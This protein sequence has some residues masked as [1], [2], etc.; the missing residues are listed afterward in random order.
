MA[1]T[2]S[3]AKIRA[4]AYNSKSI[5]DDTIVENTVF[6][7]TGTFLLLSNRAIPRN[8]KVYIETTITSNPN[9]RDIRHLPLCLGVH[10]EPSFGVLGSDCSLGGV[11][12]TR[13]AYIMGPDTTGY[14]AFTIRDKYAGQLMK[15][16]Y[17]NDTGG[18][19][20]IRGTVIGLGVDMVNNTISIYTD[21]VLFYSWIPSE[22]V[23]NDEPNDFFFAIYCSEHNEPLSGSINFGR[24]R[25]KYLPEGYMDFYQELYDKQ[26]SIGE[27]ECNIKV[28]SPYDYTS[29][30]DILNGSLHSQNDIA[31][32]D[33]I[34]HRRDIPLV[35]N[36]PD[37]MIYY[38]DES[39]GI[40]NEHA[41]T[42]TDTEYLG[43]EDDMAYIKFPIGQNKKIYFEFHSS[44]ATM[45]E[46]QMGIPL[47]IGVTKNV[48]DL[49]KDAFH[50]NLYHLR[51]D[52]YHLYTYKDGIGF[53][54]GNYNIMN[55][56]APV[57]PNEIGVLLDLENNTI[58]L[59]T[60]G[61][62][63]TIVSPY[64]SITSFED[65]TEPVYF[66]FK[67]VPEVFTGSGHVIVNLGTRSPSQMGA[68]TDDPAL[69]GFYDEDFKWKIADNQYVL[70]YW[71]YYNYPLNQ[72]FYKDLY[73]VMKVVSDHISY[74]RYISSTITIPEDT[75]I[76]KG[77][78]PG[79]NRLNSTYNKVTDI[80]ERNNVPTISIYDLKKQI[81]EDD[82][83]R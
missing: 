29:A 17:V 67:S 64:T 81:E 72:Y 69:A 78:S 68:G 33:Y 21:G 14:I 70:S 47:V 82:N 10:K 63:F 6:S 75:S 74:S 34:H 25:T 49:Y 23:M 57:Q 45:K 53:L 73:S 35:R 37:S 39:K 2:I 7:G 61:T 52:G 83:I 48:D 3:K 19:V 56:S 55:P 79:I 13:N 44:G 51:T 76:S 5:Q 65:V 18:R 28:P 43:G 50:I 1:A 80:E 12:Y 15:Y 4:I 59:Y 32:I 36:H 8:S 31:P 24:Y 26:S 58:T 9:N 27:F 41:F 22:F 11:Y 54:A 30:T 46:D 71:W 16:R 62:I 60:E 42:Y 77:W 38:K 20:P 66:F 40:I